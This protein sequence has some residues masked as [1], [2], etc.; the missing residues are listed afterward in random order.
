VASPA[1]AEAEIRLFH[2]R[3]P[4]I[5]KHLDRAQEIQKKLGKPSA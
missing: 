2:I 5:E 3:Q 1:S 4:V